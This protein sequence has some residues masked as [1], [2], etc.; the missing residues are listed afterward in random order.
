M[1][2]AAQARDDL[3][4]LEGPLHGGAYEECG[5]KKQL[6]QVLTGALFIN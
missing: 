4:R 5:L 3:L 2:A 1:P 6:T